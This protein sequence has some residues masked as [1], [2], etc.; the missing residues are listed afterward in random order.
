[1]QSLDKS[2]HLK[3]GFELIGSTGIIWNK[4]QTISHSVKKTC[5]SLKWKVKNVYP[6]K[7]DRKDRFDWFAD[8]NNRN[9]HLQVR[10]LVPFVKGLCRGT[11]SQYLDL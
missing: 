7:T 2:R 9:K 1:M 11:I 10:L 4:S 5:F 3:L 8:N 6:L